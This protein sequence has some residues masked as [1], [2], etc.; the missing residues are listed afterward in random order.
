M[1]AYQRGR[2]KGSKIKDFRWQEEFY[3]V[4]DYLEKYILCKEG[5]RYLFK[6]LE[7]VKASKEYKVYK[8]S[9]KMIP[10]LEHIYICRFTSLKKAEAALK[11]IPPFTMGGAEMDLEI[12][13]NK[14]EIWELT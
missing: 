1:C 10:S 8:E 5:E 11:A 13:S 2:T 7:T 12:V 14:T 9:C 3:I 4:F 6:Q